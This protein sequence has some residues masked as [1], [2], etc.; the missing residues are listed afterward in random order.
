MVNLDK[1]Q[2]DSGIGQ[3]IKAANTDVIEDVKELADALKSEA[4]N[5]LIAQVIAAGNK[6]QNI[7]ND[8]FKP[9]VDALIKDFRA[10]Y[11][12]AEILEKADMGEVSAADAGFGTSGI[13]ATAVSM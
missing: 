3:I 8:S 5:E 7:Y 6:F 12:I 9:S 4:D 10:V 13:D 2:L 11:D 1:E